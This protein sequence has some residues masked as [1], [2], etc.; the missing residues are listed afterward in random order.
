MHTLVRQAIQEPD[1]DERD[2]ADSASTIRLRRSQ[3]EGM[4]DRAGNLKAGRATPFIS[5]TSP[6]VEQSADL[7]VELQ[8]PVQALTDLLTMREQSGVPWER[9]S[10]CC[11][12]DCSSEVVASLLLAGTALGMDV[13]VVAPTRSR[14]SDA[15]V[16]RAH[17]VAASQL[18]SLLVTAD[19][20]R[21]LRGARFVVSIPYARGGTSTL[22]ER[23]TSDGPSIAGRS[24]IDEQAV[25]RLWVMEAALVEWLAAGPG[26]TWTRST[27]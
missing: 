4:I 10:F 5:L 13:R 2:V 17:D 6:G 24:L 15:V 18:G 12:G 19:R 20:E 16:A 14:P 3:I 23:V 26:S 1:I 8:H 11:V 7:V 25:N 9:I 27:T 22:T 21:A